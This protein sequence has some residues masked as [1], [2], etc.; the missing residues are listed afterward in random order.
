MEVELI[1]N[2]EKIPMNAFVQSI[3]AG[4]VKGAVET[5]DGIDSD[6]K[7]ISINLKR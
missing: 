1:V 7:D 6:W 5:L 3:L 2:G 4:M